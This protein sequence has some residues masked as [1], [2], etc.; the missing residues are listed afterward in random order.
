MEIKTKWDLRPLRGKDSSKRAQ[1]FIKK[2]QPRDDYL[3]DPVVLA[4]ALSDYED[5]MRYEGAAAWDYYYFILANSLDQADPKIKAGLNK[6]TERKKQL[7][8]DLRFF[9]LR[10]AKVQP[11]AHAKLASHKHFLERLL[12]QGKHQLSEEGERIISLKETTSY[13]NWMQMT[14]EFLAKE[15]RHGKNFSQISSLINSQNKK[16]RDQAAVDFNDILEK[17]LAV[18]E[19]ELNSVLQNRRTNDQLRGF[20]RPDGE[21]LLADDI[22]T[23]VVDKLVGTVAAHNDLPAKYYQLKAKLFGVDKLAYHERN[24]SYGNLEKK[25]SFAEAAALVCEVFANLHPDFAKILEGFLKNGQIDAF[26]AKGK[27]GGAACW[28]SLI[29]QPTYILLNFTG[30]LRD[31]TTLAHEAGHGINNKLIKRRQTAL[32]FETPPSTA[33]VA[34]TFMEDFVLERLMGD[35]DDQ[36]RLQLLLAK[37][38]DDLSAIFRQVAFYRFETDLHADFA[39]KGYLPRDEIGKLFLKHM[40]AYMGDYVD[41]SPGSE[42]W[43]VYV[44]HFRYYFYVYSYSS[45]LLISKFLQGKV[46]QDPEFIEKVIAFLSAGTSRAPQDL[47]LRMGADIT[48]SQFW[49]AGIA[50]FEKNLNEAWSLARQLGKI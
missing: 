42:N 32:D 16:V 2:W 9:E 35:A 10:L 43:W 38:D 22:S 41:Q 8:N 46:R 48:D 39:K 13:D 30:Q 17:N 31:V 23:A 5:L 4:Q 44:N 1:R 26:P 14:Q 18:A 40:A 37:L 27:R 28:N 6:A 49:E 36:L 45:G 21:R 34:S 3:S 33:E 20:D 19:H 50:E 12:A 47:F 7:E 15:E 29:S 11:K 24:V 25:Y